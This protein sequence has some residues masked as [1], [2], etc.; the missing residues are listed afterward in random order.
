MAEI[1]RH[2]EIRRLRLVVDN[3]DGQDRMV[4]HQRD[5]S[6]RRDLIRRW[7]T[8]SARSPNC[9]AKPLRAPGVLPNDGKVIEDS[10]QP[11]TMRRLLPISLFL[12]A[13]AAVADE[14]AL[15]PSARLL[16]AQPEL[17]QPGACVMY[18]RAGGLGSPS[19][20]FGSGGYGSR[21]RNPQ[22]PFR[23]L[24]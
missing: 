7:S 8:A 17:Q 10:Q 22:P 21:Q 1:A 15:R 23:G 18:R 13:G 19:R 2:P 4:L 20:C 6:R 9:A 14:P 24:P 3:P 12:L 11:L 16:F 5:R